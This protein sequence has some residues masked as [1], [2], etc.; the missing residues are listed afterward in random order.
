MV[1]LLLDTRA[2]VNAADK[3]LHIC[4]QL[5]E[6]MPVL[7]KHFFILLATNHR[8]LTS[9]GQPLDRRSTI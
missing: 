1:R 4:S 7:R 6:L 9:A 8:R 5:D 3:V 2:D